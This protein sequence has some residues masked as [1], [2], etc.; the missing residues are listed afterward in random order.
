MGADK[1]SNRQRMRDIERTDWFHYKML[2]G[3]FIWTMGE[4][5]NWPEFIRKGHKEKSSVFRPS[6]SKENK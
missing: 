6:K 1:G 4:P 3:K 2:D 5:I